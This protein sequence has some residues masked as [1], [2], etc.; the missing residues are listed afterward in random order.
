MQ[1][2]ANA[3]YAGVDTHKDKHV[4][5]LLDGLGRKTF[6]GEFPA[7]AEGYDALARA[8]G[9]PGACPVVGIE[10]TASFGAGLTA[11]LQNLGF[12]VME[13]LRPKRDKRR[14]GTDKSDAVDAELAA[15]HAAAGD[16]TSVPKSRD[17]WAEAVRALVRAREIAV[18]ITTETSNAAKSLIGTAPEHI[19]ARYSDMETKDMM[20]TLSRKR[21]ESGDMVADALMSSLRAIA[22]T[23]REQDLRASELEGRIAELARE[24]APALLEVEGCGPLSAAELAIAAGDN[25]SRMGSEAA[26]ASLCGVCPIEASSGKT[27]RH[28]L[29]RGGNRRANRA[30]HVIVLN[31]MKCDDRTKEYVE[32]RTRDGKS[33]REIM[34]C[35]KRYVA[36]E[37]FR[38]LLHPAETRHPSGDALRAKR[39]SA[40]LT[41]K[42]VAARLGVENIRISEIERNVRK[43][44]EIR[45]RYAN[46][47]GDLSET[48][49]STLDTQ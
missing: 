46:L 5:C 36:R 2:V 41:Q 38:A 7:D 15:R 29:N 13:V 26:F 6:V 42:E 14:K 9:D 23:W 16:G 37:V 44:F 25:P 24:N 48:S 12:N 31:R 27:V 17:G 32:R 10:G 40:G 35:L 18:R 4:L 30:L 43:H 45:D 34:R 3:V 22:K 28:R 8:I 39:V 33:K 47:L 21:A 11:R 1:D 20:R 19:R 49:E